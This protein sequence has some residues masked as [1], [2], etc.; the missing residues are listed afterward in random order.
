MD[1]DRRTREIRA[2]IA[3]TREEMS[4]TIE[5]IQDRLTPAHL[6]EQAKETVR[7]AASRKMQQ[8]KNT[9]GD[10]VQHMANT[11]G[12]AAER[13]IDS[14][15]AQT[16]RS[17]PI[18][19]AMIGVGAAWLLMKRRSDSDRDQYNRGSYRTEP[20]ADWRNPRVRAGGTEYGRYGAAETTPYGSDDTVQTGY[21]G[22]SSGGSTGSW[23]SMR[24]NRG[25]QISLDRVVRDN[26]LALGAAAVLVGA[27]IGMSVPSTETENH[28]MGEARDTMIDR[29]REMATDAAE[30]VSDTADQVKDI[31]ARAAQ[32]AGGDTSSPDRR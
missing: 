19:I 5:A 26:P 28:L 8:M 21:A 13:V 1:T 14:S 32:A 27:A 2:E 20:G 22:S 16:V 29:A 17:N 30:K 7:D 15:F 6:V 9:A 31:A 10:K 25:P 18:P 4:E 23:G 3:Q 12:S 24:P 11:A